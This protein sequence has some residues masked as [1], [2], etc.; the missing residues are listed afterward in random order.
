MRLQQCVCAWC[1]IVPPYLF[2]AMA[3]SADADVQEAV[4]NTR[5]AD[6]IFRT[7]RANFIAS[8]PMSKLSLAATSEP[9]RRV[10]FDCE[11]TNDLARRQVLVEGGAVPADDSVREAYA[12]A[13]TTWNFYNQIFQRSSVDNQGL[14]LVSSVHYRRRYNNAVW[15]GQQMAY[16]DGDGVIFDRFTK[17]L[18]V[19]G[20]ELT[21]GVTQY[22]AGL[23]YESQ[24]GALNEHFSDVFG[25]LV[26]Q[27]SLKQNNPSTA[28]WLIGEGLFKPSINGKAL[29]SMS[30]PGTAYNDPASG[31]G[32][33]PQPAHMNDYKQL[34]NTEAG[35][36]GGVHINS[37]IPNRAFYL[38]AQA[39]GKPAWE[40]AGKIWYVTLTERLRPDADFN[41]CAT[42]TISVAR[43]FFGNDVAEKVAS[44]WVAVGVIKAGS[45]PLASF[46]AAAIRHVRDALRP[47][48]AKRAKKASA[49]KATAR[50]ATA[51]KA[52]SARGRAVAKAAKSRAKGKRAR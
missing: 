47:G 22:T 29:R 31:L 4:R 33:D 10:V 39:I 17:S 8:T 43:D 25:T 16:G 24:S 2:D 50:R 18:D 11:S 7:T 12:G 52:A 1:S 40:T 46:A 26:K 28:G 20:H 3:R 15:N 30:D 35:D 32:K 44:A 45:R 49:K 38:A 41:K 48:S 5:E 36:Y 6:V 37:G 42:E 27:W 14:T 23:K 9:L 21:H 19:I 13:E 51:K 34:P